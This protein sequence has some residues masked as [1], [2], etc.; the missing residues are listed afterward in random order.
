M[1]ILQSRSQGFVKPYTTVFQRSFNATGQ[2]PVK[3]TCSLFCLLTCQ[4]KAP[5]TGAL[6]TSAR[7]PGQSLRGRAM[8]NASLRVSVSFITPNA[9]RQRTENLSAWNLREEAK[10]IGIP[11]FPNSRERLKT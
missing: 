2:V 11:G 6:T 4:E 8:F 3:V 10:H 1:F 9:K 5:F 7:T